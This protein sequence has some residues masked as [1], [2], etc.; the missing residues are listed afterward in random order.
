MDKDALVSEICR[1]VEEK[2]Q[3]LETGTEP[4]NEE[5]KKG[6]RKL[7]LLTEE[8]GDACHE[9]L[10]NRELGAC[11]HVECAL[12][13][14]NQRRID[15]Y[16]GIVVY[17]LSVGALAKLAAGIVDNGFT[18][19]FAEALLKGK[20]IWLV[21]EGIELCSYKETA[22]PAYYRLMEE[23]LEFL[24]EAGVIVAA[25]D[26]IP[27]MITGSGAVCP[28][29]RCAQAECSKN[30]EKKTDTADAGKTGKTAV[31]SKKIITERDIVLLAQEKTV[32]VMVGEH[33]IFTDLAKEYAAKHKIEISRDP[34]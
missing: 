15:D 9:F 6:K 30:A 20:K 8:H 29:V 17:T 7:L 21:K 26:Q 18:G 4:E 34:A 23:K 1:R 11:F 25:R 14:D 13:A 24:K 32:K 10:K 22:A 27:G 16:E 12:L 5:E 19:L 33:A 3:A 28:E 2:L 31:L